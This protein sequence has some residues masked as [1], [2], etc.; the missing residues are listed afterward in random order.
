MP[1]QK[2]AWIKFLATVGVL[3]LIVPACAAL[4]VYPNIKLHLDAK[5]KA[6]DDAFYWKTPVPL[7]DSTRAPAKGEP[8]AYAG[9]AFSAPWELS[10]SSAPRVMNSHWAFIDFETGLR[11]TLVTVAP[12]EAVHVTVELPKGGDAGAQ[13]PFDITV[14]NY[15]DMRETLFSTPATVRIFTSRAK[16]AAAADALTRKWEL[17]Q[18]HNDGIFTVNGPECRGFQIGSLVTSD[19]GIRLLLYT[20]K[21]NVQIRIGKQHPDVGPPVTQADVNLIVQTLRDAD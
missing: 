9:V 10:A 3:A 13:Y 19:W 16:A 18:N 12:G 11:M 17:T 21:R 20:G 7:S 8:I 14:P 15:E 5:F 6:R 4:Y 1:N 2:P